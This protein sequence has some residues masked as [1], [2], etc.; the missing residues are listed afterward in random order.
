MLRKHIPDF[1]IISGSGR[2]V[3]KTFLASA[4]IRAFSDTVP[5]IALKISP[6]VHNLLGHTKLRSNADG[7]R[8]FQDMEPHLKSSGKFLESGALQSYFME[9]DDEHLEEA[10]ELFMS[11]CN[12]S[13]HPVICETGALCRLV[14]P[15]I[16][17]FIT[18]ST[19][20]LP[21]PKLKTLNEANLV[22]PARTFSTPEI[23]QR[24]SFSQKNW[25]LA[26]I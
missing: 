3:G 20:D 12:P 7:F 26:S 8:I 21:A 14:K 1:I 2:K 18:S 24:I 25:H 4:L 11:E 9:T 13:G 22:L 5:I 17:I 23:I 16:L 10:F 19:E 15:G 6:H